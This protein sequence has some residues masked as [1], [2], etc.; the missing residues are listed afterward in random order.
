MVG[1]SE[2]REARRAVRDA[3]PLLQE[4]DRVKIV[5]VCG[6]E[7]DQ[8]VVK[9]LDD[10]SRYLLRHRIKADCTVMLDRKGAGAEQLIRIAEEERADLLV[11]GAYGHSRLGEWIFGGMTLGLLASSPVC[12][13]FSN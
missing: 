3:L 2:S 6:V 1:W 8:S 13:L 9:H 10:L 5:Q 11:T 7:E 12:C 4:A